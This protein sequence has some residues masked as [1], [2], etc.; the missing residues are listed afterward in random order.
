[1]KSVGNQP[2]FFGPKHPIYPQV[3][4]LVRID[5]P[6][7]ATDIYPGYIQ[8]YKDGAP[9]DRE[10]CYVH[11]PNGDELFDGRY[12]LARLVSSHEG[13]PLLATA[14]CGPGSGSGVDCDEAS[15]DEDDLAPGCDG[16]TLW[17]YQRTITTHVSFTYCQVWTTYT[18]WEQLQDLCAPCDCESLPPE[19]EDD[20]FWCVYSDGVTYCVKSKDEPPGAVGGPFTSPA[21]CASQCGDSSELWWC[22]SNGGDP[23]C[24]ESATP[25]GGLLSGPYGSAVACA[26]VCDGGGIE[27]NCCPENPVSASLWAVISGASGD[28]SCMNGE[29]PLSYR[30]LSEDWYYLTTSVC[31]GDPPAASGLQIRLECIGGVWTL[32]DATRSCAPIGT[33]TVVSCVPGSFHLTGTVNESGD[34]CGSTMTIDI[35][36]VDPTP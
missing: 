2:P 25:P 26:E 33:L 14:C 13:L 5:G 6:A 31:T 15:T 12:Y 4:Q 27:T 23:T 19:G 11:E 17:L 8:Q 36:D 18:A 16:A 34:C 22:V 7:V 30:V 28:C 21:D 3:D 9:R 32:S 35:Y 24:V 20:F 10:E 29:W 1:M